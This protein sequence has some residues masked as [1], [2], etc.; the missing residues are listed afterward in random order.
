[1]TNFRR[2]YKNGDVFVGRVQGFLVSQGNLR[3]DGW[4][5]YEGFEGKESLHLVCV[6]S[7]VYLNKIITLSVRFYY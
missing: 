7:S 1:M 3:D 4:S 2:C 6:T 5:K